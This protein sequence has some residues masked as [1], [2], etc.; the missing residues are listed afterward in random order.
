MKERTLLKSFAEELE[1][2]IERYEYLVNTQATADLTGFRELR[3]WAKQMLVTFEFLTTLLISISTVGAGLVYATIFSAS[4]GNVELMCLSFPL[5]TAG[6]LVP[7]IIQ[8]LLKL[9]SKLPYPVRFGS[10]RIWGYIISVFLTF[11]V[12][13]V[14]TA[15]VILNLTVFFLDP[16]ATSPVNSDTFRI[17]VSGVAV[18]AFSSFVF[19]LAFAAFAG[20]FCV[21]KR[22]PIVRR[23]RSMHVS[24]ASSALQNFKHV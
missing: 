19:L 3:D 6:F 11:A 10:Q 4:R 14:L 7:M 22:V 17:S 1:E 13:T 9:A 24:D 12:I 21:R 20:F 18:F 16:N 23:A 2:S 15:L 8:V 5:F